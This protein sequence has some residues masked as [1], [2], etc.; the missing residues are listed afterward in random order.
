MY[1][2]PRHRRQRAAAELRRYTRSMSVWLYPLLLGLLA[3]SSAVVAQDRD[4]EEC[5]AFVA[6]GENYKT[7]HR[8]EN[9]LRAAERGSGSAQYSVGMAYGFA[10]DRQLEEKYYRL[11]AD[12]RSVAAYL[13][14]G[15][16]LADRSPWES[17]YW[18]QRYVA[19]KADG[20]G[21]AA[22]LLSK[23]FER[24]GERGQAA[25]WLEVCSKSEYTGCTR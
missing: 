19:T 20:Y 22:L 11:A 7:A 9:C 4:V 12:Q 2:V 5:N 15:H 17:I 18:Y 14:L 24:L 1:K 10:G 3:S 6:V 13:A 21:Y 16:L 8:N 25:Y 23:S